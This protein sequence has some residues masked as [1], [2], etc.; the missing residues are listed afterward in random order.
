MLYT[1]KINDSSTK[2]QS[3]INLLKTFAKDYD[4][5]QIYKGSEY[6]ITEEMK[7]ELDRRY[8]YFLQNP[9]EGK[10]WDEVRRNLL[11]K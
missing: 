9:D 8:E 2:A 5:L 10:S 4:F 1:I 11:K 3:I 7:K 6:E